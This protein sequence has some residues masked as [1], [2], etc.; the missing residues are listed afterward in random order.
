[1]FRELIVSLDALAYPMIGLGSFL[2][3]FAVVLGRAL[4][5]TPDE[6]D[7]RAQLPFDERNH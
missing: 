1:M 3:A 7:A 2:F 5:E 4:R 6:L